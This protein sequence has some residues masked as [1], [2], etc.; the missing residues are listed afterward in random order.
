MHIALE[1]EFGSTISAGARRSVVALAHNIWL[2]SSACEGCTLPFNTTMEVREGLTLT[3][4]PGQLQGRTGIP[5]VDSWLNAVNPH[6]M[7]RRSGVYTPSAPPPVTKSVRTA[8]PT[9]PPHGTDV[10][11]TGGAALN[12]GATP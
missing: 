3:M 8:R 4:D 6:H 2:E 11:L 10:H 1:Y 12:V 7:L 5:V 9:W